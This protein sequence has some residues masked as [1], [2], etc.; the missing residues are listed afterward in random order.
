MRTISMQ[1]T[2]GLVRGA[3]VSDTGFPIR[4]PV[5]DLV[6]VT[7]SMSRRV[8]GHPRDSAA[9]ASSGASTVSPR[10]STS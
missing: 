5:G 10:L 3:A 1:P 7:S 8:P 6:K 4:V 2:D 9:T